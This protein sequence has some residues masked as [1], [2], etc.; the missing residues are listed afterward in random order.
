MSETTAGAET[1][2]VTC[3][4]NDPGVEEVV[5][6]C[7]VIE[8]SDDDEE[9]KPKRRRRKKPPSDQRHPCEVC[10]KTFQ[11]GYELKKHAR[12]HTGERPYMCT[13]CGK[14]YTQLGHLSIHQLAH[15]GSYCHSY[16][17]QC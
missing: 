10:E 16:K 15:K 9:P 17:A 12:T 1:K 14:T 4:S 11:T 8:I 5:I 2:E 6:K 13:T 3:E 7:D